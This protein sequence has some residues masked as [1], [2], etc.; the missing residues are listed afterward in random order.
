MPLFDVAI[1]TERVEA[2]RSCARLSTARRLQ[3]ARSVWRQRAC[4]TGEARVTGVAICT[5]RVEAKV[6]FLCV[7]DKS[8]SCN[9]HG[10]CG[11]KGV[12][13]NA[14]LSARQLQSARSV[15]RQSLRLNPAAQIA[16]L[17]SAR[18]VW[19]QRLTS[20]TPRSTRQVAICTERV[21][22]KY[23]QPFQRR[24][25]EFVAICTE[26]V[27]AKIHTTLFARLIQSLQSAR[28]VWKVLQYPYTKNPRKFMQTYCIFI[29]FGV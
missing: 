7:S 27:E 14:S 28:G 25:F 8:Q 20:L 12:K 1:C 17:Q 15:W 18:S 26:R 2:K 16:R 5:E 6:T 9:L 24:P 23:K 13:R 21:E 4:V 10:A 3:S 22:A 11:G 29:H 19:R